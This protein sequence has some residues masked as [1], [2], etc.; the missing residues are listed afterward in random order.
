MTTSSSAQSRPK[1]LRAWSL[2]LALAAVLAGCG[3]E[4][5][6]RVSGVAP[7]APE[8]NQCQRAEQYE[9]QNLVDFEP[10]GNSSW[11]VCDPKFAMACNEATPT[12]FYFNYDFAHTYPPPP[13][14]SGV[15]NPEVVTC[16]R[17]DPFDA[18]LVQAQVTG[19]SIKDGARCGVSEHALNVRASNVAECYGGNGRLGWGA[20]LDLTMRG[21]LG[22]DGSPY[23]G[24]SFWV[25][26]G[27]TATKP[28]LVFSVVDVENNGIDDDTLSGDVLPQCGCVFEPTPE[29]PKHIHCYSDPP[30]SVPDG[31]KCD[32]FSAAVTLTDEWTLVAARFSQL[33]QKGFGAASRL[34]EV[35]AARIKRLQFLMTAGDWDFW[36]DDLALF[37]DAE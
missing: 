2:G 15:L 5:K 37:K 35:N 12:P 32:A 9:F 34:P 21:A 30:P 28:T 3:G 13:P 25:R 16:P 14:P 1:A 22:L 24:I 7:I 10:V 27:A 18:N 33:S 26:K 8:V 36:I 20:G 23:D 11:A 31:R 4:D 6:G 29:D 19:S 17:E